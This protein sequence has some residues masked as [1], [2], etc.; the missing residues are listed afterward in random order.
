MASDLF[1]VGVIDPCLSDHLGLEM[2]INEN[3]QISSASVKIRNLSKKNLNNFNKSVQ[4]IN[5]DIFY[6]DESNANLLTDFVLSTFSNLIDTHFP[7]KEISVKTNPFIPTGWFTDNLRSMRTTLTALKTISDVTKSPQDFGV[8]KLFKK[9]YRR[10]I[11]NAKFNSYRQ[12]LTNSKNKS[13]DSWKLI[14]HESNN[15]RKSIECKVEA[16]DFNEFFCTVSSTIISSLPNSHV[17]YSDHLKKMPR[18]SSSFYLSPVGEHDVASAIIKLK[19]SNCYDIYDINTKMLKHCYKTIVPYLTILINKCFTEG[20]FPD[21]LKVAKVLPIFKKGNPDQADNYRPISI[22]PLFGKIIES[23][24][25]DKLIS[26]FE[27]LKILVNNQFGFRSGRSTISGILEV[28]NDIVEGLDGGELRSAA[29]CDLSKA[30][31]CVSH[32]ILLDKL[33]YY[34]ING[35]PH[36]LLQSYLSNRK[37]AVSINGKLSNL[38][39]IKTGVPQGSILG[40]LLFIIY[41]NDFSTSVIPNKCVLY[42]DDATIIVSAVSQDSLQ[43]NTISA[44][45]SAQ[46]WF[47]SNSLKLNNDKT[48]KITFSFSSASIEGNYVK[49]LGLLLDD[50]LKWSS[51]IDNLC[52]RLSGQIYLLRQLKK[53]FDKKILLMVYFANIHSLLSY[54]AVIWGNASQSDKAFKM[55]KRAVRTIDGLGPRDSCR[56]TFKKLRIMPLSCIYLYLSYSP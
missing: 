48:Q 4:K 3:S 22:L 14:K 1:R 29:L 13:K 52:S 51:H 45:S 17:S 40:P 31:D 6:K 12:Y 33:N 11:N 38:K 41:I 35:T 20:I 55:Q 34:G 46:N 50:G 54:G 25:K 37:Q 27:H 2:C 9:N 10:E 36:L 56:V 19:N 21:S 53:T 15:V 18:P 5:W 43:Q 30:F 7:F 8:Y 24:M 26:Y 28:V 47:S 39:D 49:L 44:L 32:A 16:E 42:A 23:V